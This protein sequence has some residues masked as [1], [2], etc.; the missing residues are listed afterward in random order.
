MESL[1]I[2]A[3]LEELCATLSRD[4]AL[5][6][7]A[8]PGAGKTTRLPAAL[9]ER[10][11][12]GGGQVVVLE[13]RRVAARAAARRVAYERDWELG[14]RVG[15]Q[16]RFD[17]RVSRSTR[18]RFVTEG[19]L[20]RELQG[21]PELASASIV[22][23]DEFHER[24]IHA[25]LALALLA[26]V[27]RSLRP[28]LRLVVMSATLA[29]EPIARFLGNAPIV[30]VPGRTFPLE[31]EELSIA[32]DSPIAIRAATGVRRAIASTSGDVLAILPG[33]GE[34]LRTAD[35]LASF[36]RERDLVVLPLYGDLSAE[37][38]DRA[39]RSSDRR[40]VILATNVAE[41][42]L[43][44]PGVTAVVD[45]GLVRVLVHDPN[46]GLDRLEL[47]PISRASAT[48][49]AGRAG[50]VGP[51]RVLQ[52]WTRIDA[53]KMPERELPEIARVDLAPTLL[54]LAVWGVRDARSF[55]WFEAPDD[56]SI[57]RATELLIEL[58][59]ID[60]STRAPTAI[61][62]AMADLPCHPRLARMLVE[63]AKLG[64]LADGALLAALLSERDLFAARRGEAHQ[65]VGPSDLL[66][67][68]D[69]LLERSGNFDRGLVRAIERTADQ[70]ERAAERSVRSAKRAEASDE[71]LLR[72][73]FAGYVDRVA[74]RRAPKGDEAR[75]V[76][77]RGLVF[78]QES[79]VRDAELFVVIDAD[80]G[81]RGADARARVRQ[82]SAID[83]GWLA[84]VAGGMLREVRETRFDELR[85]RA[86][87]V[88]SLMYRD[89]AIEEGE[90]GAPEPAEATRLL[91]E[92]AR[93]HPERA[94][95]LSG[96]VGR[97]IARLRSL[98]NWMPELALPSH[99]E[100]DLVGALESWSDGLSSVDELR[101]L[102]LGDVVRSRLTREQAR[103]LD[104]FAPDALPLPSGNQRRLE[105]EP[106]KP[107]VLAVR[108]QELF[109]LADT[110]TVA[111]GRV[112]VLLHLLA[113]NQRVVQ[114][115]QDLSSF[116]NTT[117][118]QVRKDL[119]AR[120]PKHSWPEDPWTAQPTSRTTRRRPN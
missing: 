110:P 46:V 63:A 38:Q 76:G 66:A 15:Y 74:K 32:D 2:D 17:S 99:D 86:F 70:L 119:R 55:G 27:R 43:T 21:D 88:K 24:S 82:A 54:E 113:P 22:V 5:V 59:A 50:R 109:G 81:R 62:R 53:L 4:G 34:I 67:R 64:V 48:Q 40:R 93:A 33:V 23:L 68:R 65:S 102:P 19:I 116:W 111:R 103:A 18:L 29:A 12:A 58:G 72:V 52:L 98:A 106:G 104:E 96:D 71:T 118:A 83:R 49:R 42:S 39:L 114:V 97:T 31:I 14:G 28:D 25:D 41:T 101:A 16:V 37:E 20:T 75:M 100:L 108:L 73:I 3:H 7:V 56:A 8:E 13:P 95:D 30:R 78:A 79:V 112:R 80:L 45:T 105:Y 115:T 36:A 117:Y 77:G 61:G 94:I 87:G 92:F 51:G 60:P 47:R 90:T 85:G 10:G 11:V 120:Y 26:E 35:E 6:L 9:L 44:V 1:P 89:L 91:F 84:D 107:P 69:A 57:E